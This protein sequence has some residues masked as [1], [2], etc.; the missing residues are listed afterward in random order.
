M[1]E[2]DEVEKKII[3]VLENVVDFYYKSEDQDKDK[4]SWWTANV[5]DG[6]CKLAADMNYLVTANGCNA[7]ENREWLFDMVWTEPNFE[8]LI[9]A[10][11]CGWDRNDGIWRDFEKL[12]VVRSKYRIFIFNSSKSEEIK[13]LMKEFIEKIKKFKS[14]LPEDRYLLAG[15]SF[16]EGFIFDGIPIIP[17]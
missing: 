8:E 10:M 16:K 17:N 7:Y 3:S 6:F 5:K 14:T 2:L 9:L 4:R 12:L 13:E 15:Y 11:E 1:K